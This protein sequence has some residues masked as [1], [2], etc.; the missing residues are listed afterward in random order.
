MSLLKHKIQY[1]YFLSIFVCRPLSVIKSWF[2][3]LTLAIAFLNSY[4]MPRNKYRSVSK[5][6]LYSRYDSALLEVFSFSN[7][8]C[9]QQSFTISVRSRIKFS[10]FPISCEIQAYPKPYLSR[11]MRLWHLSPS[12]N[13]IFKHACATIQWGY[14]SDFWSDPSSTSIL[15]VC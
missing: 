4:G 10:G 2:E 7:Q 8:F 6:V 12:V 15:Y 5:S 9:L 3:H 13:S 11:L 1:L 14:T